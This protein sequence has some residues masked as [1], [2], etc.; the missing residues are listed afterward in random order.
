[1]NIIDAVRK[2]RWDKNRQGYSTSQINLS[3]DQG[4]EL[5]DLSV[6]TPLPV[7]D[8][9]RDVMIEPVEKRL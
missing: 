9:Q 7:T 5:L 8:A 4:F 6:R 3:V 2:A 1:M